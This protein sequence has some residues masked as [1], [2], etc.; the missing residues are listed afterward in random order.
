YLDGRARIT[1]RAHVSGV[2]LFEEELSFGSGEGR[3]AVVDAEGR[4][5]GIDKS[6]RLALTFDTRTPDQVAPLL[7]SIGEVL[8]A[9]RAAG[10]EAFLAYGTLLGAVREGALIG[11]ES[12]AD[13]GYVSRFSHPADVVAESFRL[14]RRLVAMGYAISRYSGADL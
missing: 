14:Q 7:D 9:L 10:V 5:L 3:I 8:D 4:P 11:H 6:G 2:E 12:D 1:V 13:L